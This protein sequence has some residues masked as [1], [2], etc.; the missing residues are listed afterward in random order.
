MLVLFT[1]SMGSCTPDPSNQSSA[2]HDQGPAETTTASAS[3]ISSSPSS[4]LPRGT[5]RT[6]VTLDSSFSSVSSSTTTPVQ[7]PNT[8]ETSPEVA[9]SIFSTNS[10]GVI[11]AVSSPY[12]IGWIRP[13][14]F[15]SS[16][17]GTSGLFLPA[18][19]I[20]PPPSGATLRTGS[21]LYE[22]HPSFSARSSYMSK[23]RWWRVWVGEPSPHDRAMKPPPFPEAAEAGSFDSRMVIFSGD[24]ACCANW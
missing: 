16:H 21:F 23:A 3:R 2:L 7:I 18:C 24:L 11:W 5:N 14:D 20:P 9:S 17:E 1:P 22:T 8:T 15:P 6:P 4:L 19:L 13:I 10:L 12:P